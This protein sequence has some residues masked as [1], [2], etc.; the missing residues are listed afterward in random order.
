MAENWGAEQLSIYNDFVEDGFQVTVRV[1]GVPGTFNPD[2]LVYDG[3]TAASDIDTF[4]LKKQYDI[5]Q[6]DGTIIQS[7]DTRLLF[8]AYGL[9]SVTTDNVIV[10]G[11][12]EVSVVSVKIVDPGNVALIYEVQIRG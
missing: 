4:G 10:I 11:T 3:A 7:G 1:P 5:K 8:P 2:T 12:T 6:I 9:G